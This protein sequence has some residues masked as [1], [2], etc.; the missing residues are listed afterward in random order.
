MGGGIVSTPPFPLQRKQTFLGP[1]LQIFF[2]FFR[3]ICHILDKTQNPFL[4][5]LP[6]TDYRTVYLL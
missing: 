6:R 1:A 4:L 5:S 2:F 3:E